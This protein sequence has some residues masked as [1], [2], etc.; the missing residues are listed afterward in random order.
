MRASMSAGITATDMEP[1]T[2]LTPQFPLLLLDRYRL[3][4]LLG[5]NAE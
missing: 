3:P 2:L 1:D 5:E 4:P